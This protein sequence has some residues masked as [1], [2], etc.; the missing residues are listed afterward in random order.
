MQ[1][2]PLSL[3]VHIP[4]CVRKCPYCDFNSHAQQGD[5]P[6]QGYIECL[7][8]DLERCSVFAA[9]RK[10][11]SIFFGG[12]T[13]SLFSAKGIEAILK[14]AKA[15]VGFDEAIEIT[16]EANPGTFEQKRFE[17]YRQAGVNR[18]SIGV[19]S[20]S[21]EQLKNLG[22]I[23]TES[24]ASQAIS[25]AQDVGFDNINIDLMHGLSKQS[26]AQALADLEQA[27]A[28]NP[29][30]IS[31]YQ[32]TIEKNTAFYNRPP[33]LPS[34][35][36]LADIEEAG[37]ELLH[38][39]GFKRYEISAFCRD[40]QVSKHNMNYWQFGDYFGIGAGAHGKYTD[41][42]SNSVYRSQLTRTP[43]HY[44][45]DK[46]RD[47]SWRKIANDQLPFE[48]M[49]NALRLSAGVPT[50]YFEQRTGLKLNA[51]QSR[52]DALVEKGLLVDESKR[53][54]T[55]KLGQRY[56]NDVLNEFI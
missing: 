35:D 29:N 50:D 9:G 41:I 1:L 31:W 21:S 19:Q 53:I 6:E 47:F 48:F 10:L 26:P 14:A 32:L 23:H 33:P 52:L 56:L 17:G 43:A 36:Q 2:A 5:L 44:M 28:L 11:H 8:A 45:E 15:T 7:L 39:A 30:H 37:F 4:W 42:H 13:P 46:A 27:L 3:Y 24:E 38:K 54:A 20:F 55:T 25:C 51:I 22:R 40:N 18:L 12:G 49:M 34:D 16:L